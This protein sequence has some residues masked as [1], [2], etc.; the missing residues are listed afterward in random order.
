MNPEPRKFDYTLI[1]LLLANLAP[2]Y[3]VIY[4]DWSIFQ[5]FLLFWMDTV[6][7]GFYSALKITKVSGLFSFLLIPFFGLH[8]GIFM[9]AYLALIFTM[10]NEAISFTTII[11]SLS[12]IVESG[13][14]LLVPIILLFISH[15]ISYYANYIKKEEYKYVDSKQQVLLSYS[16]IIVMHLLIILAGWIIVFHDTPTSAVVLLIVGK[17]IV[18]AKAHMLSHQKSAPNNS[19]LVVKLDPI[20]LILSAFRK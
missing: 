4:G 3:G 13:K 1:P 14:I 18:D 16:R 2:I 15:G 6:V 19:Q 9:F 10:F 17:I 7:V 20:N 8:F 12:L 5:V 11:P